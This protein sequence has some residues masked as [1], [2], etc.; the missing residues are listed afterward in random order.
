MPVAL[1]RLPSAIRIHSLTPAPAS[2]SPALSLRACK[3]AA[4]TSHLPHPPL[5]PT[6]PYSSKHSRFERPLRTHSPTR[7]RHSPQIAVISCSHTAPPLPLL[8]PALALMLWRLAAMYSSGAV[9]MWHL[10]FALASFCAAVSCQWGG[11]RVAHRGSPQGGAH[12]FGVKVTKKW[13]DSLFEPS[14][15]DASGA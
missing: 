6:Q 1:V 3:A 11:S 12:G 10:I 8:L 2:A 7:D 15:V 9:D 5:P 14:D 4:P 13:D